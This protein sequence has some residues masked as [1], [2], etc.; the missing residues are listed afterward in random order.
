MN[1]ELSLLQPLFLVIRESRIPVFPVLPNE[2]LPIWDNHRSK[3]SPFVPFGTIP[4]ARLSQMGQF[5]ELAGHEKRMDIT[6]ATV[7]AS[8]VM[9]FFGTVQPY[10]RDV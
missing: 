10:V 4:R 7:L 1:T 5:F 9:V 6:C 8:A 3:V 2:E